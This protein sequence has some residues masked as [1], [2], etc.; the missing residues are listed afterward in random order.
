[1]CNKNEIEDESH[2][3][4]NCNFY[5]DDR[6]TLLHDICIEDFTNSYD[7]LKF[8]MSKKIRLLARFLES[9][10]KQRKSVMY[11]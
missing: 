11:N 8:L 3:I 6:K 10:Y 5:Q 2:F 4:L 9:A 7:I 1:M